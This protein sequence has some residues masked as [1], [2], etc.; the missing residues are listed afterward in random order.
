MQAIITPIVAF[1][2]LLAQVCFG[3]TLDEGQ[4]QIITDGF[5]AFALALT[6]MVGVVKAYQEKK[7]KK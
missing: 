4:Q 6:T 3:I 7:Q 2:G 1:L 5:I